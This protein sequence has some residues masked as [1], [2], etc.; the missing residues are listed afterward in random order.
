MAR[1]RHMWLKKKFYI[2]SNHN[3]YLHVSRKWKVNHT[4]VLRKRN[5]MI[6]FAGRTMMLVRIPTTRARYETS[7]RP[8][9]PRYCTG[10]ET[11]T[12]NITICFPVTQ[13]HALMTVGSPRLFALP[14]FLPL[15]R[16]LRTRMQW[17]PCRTW[18]GWGSRSGA[19]PEWSDCKGG[20]WPVRT[21]GDSRQSTACPCTIAPVKQRTMI[22]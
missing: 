2:V 14:Q 21:T 16:C 9:S 17:W 1:W 19:A 8:N 20:E 11:T 5:T 18:A 10:K 7:S 15:S 12:Y 22:L 13:L 6:M 4:F 3:K